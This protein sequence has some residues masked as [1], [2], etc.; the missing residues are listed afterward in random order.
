[1]LAEEGVPGD[2]LVVVAEYK[3]VSQ[4]A[5]GI[6][7]EMVVVAKFAWVVLAVHVEALG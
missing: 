6:D 2:S 4:A 3:Q 7:S 5:A 1:M